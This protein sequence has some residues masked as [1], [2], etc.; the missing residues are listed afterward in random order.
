MLDAVLC[1]RIFWFRNI[2]NS[3]PGVDEKEEK[4]AILFLDLQN[5]PPLLALPLLQHTESKVVM[6]RN[7]KMFSLAYYQEEIASVP[8]YCFVHLPTSP[9]SKNP[10]DPLDLLWP[11]GPSAVGPHVLLQSVI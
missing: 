4:N 5:F 10:A 6:V 11:S 3:I 8:R 9:S 2:K 1:G 7:Q